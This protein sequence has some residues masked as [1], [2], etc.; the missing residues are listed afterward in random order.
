MKKVLKI[1]GIIL[2]VLLAIM[3][4]LP[5]AFKSKVGGI[6]QKQADHY[7][8]AKMTFDDLSL[9][10]FRNFPN[11]TASLNNFMIIGT[12]SFAHD[13]LVYSKSA[14][15]AIDL[16]SLMTDSGFRI[17]KV[18]LKNAKV[19]I[20]TLVSGEA[21]W[22]I[23]KPDTTP[24]EPSAD[25]TALHFELDKVELTNARVIYDDRKRDMLAD[26]QGWNGSLNGDLSS[27]LTTISTESVIES[28]NYTL[29]GMPVLKD[30]KMDFQLTFD[31]DLDRYI[32]NF[33]SNKI[34]LNAI[35]LG[36]G[37][38]ISLPG[39]NIDFDLKANTEKVTFK[40]FL[41][42][43]P[44]F[45]T[46]V[47]SAMKTAG[48]LK[49]DFF[50]KGLMTDEDW[51]A[52]GFKLLVENAMF[53]YPSL[54]KSV[55]DIQIDCNITNPGGTMDKTLVDL[56]KFHFNLGGN[57]FDLTAHVATPQSDP[58][59]KGTLAG[60]LNLGML[61]EVYPLEKGT[62]LQGRIDANLAAGGK[63][64]WLDKKQYDK[65]FLKGALAVSGI[66]Y[67]SEGMP[68]VNVQTAKMDFSPRNVH[69]T[70]LSV[71][72]GKN[73]LQANGTLNNMLGWFMHDEVLS[74]T[75]QMQS[76]YLNLND[77]MSGETTSSTDTTP[78]MAFEIPQNLDLSLNAIGKK[79]LFNSLV[80]NNA[81][82][83]LTV[84][85]GRV[86]I[87]DLSANALGGSIGV[88]GYYEALNPE[89]P[90]VAFGLDLKSVSFA[91]TF[92][93]FDFVKKIA[94]IFEQVKGNYSMK[95]DFNTLLDKHLNPDLKLLDG[96]GRMQSSG[97]SVSNIK[98][99]DVLAS[100]LKNNKLRTLAPKDLNIPFK[101]SEGKVTTSPFTVKVEGVALELGGITGL[102]KTIDYQLGVTL[103]SN[104]V[105]GGVT[106]LQGTIKGTFSKPVIK[107]NTAA[108]AKQVA[109]T[110][111]DKAL[112]STLGTNTAETIAKANEELNKK[113]DEMR[114]AAKAAGDKLISEA[115]SRGDS[116]IAKAK[117]PMVKIAAQ[118]T[119]S[120][121][122][123]EAQKKAASLLA[124][125][126]AR[127]KRMMA[128]AQTK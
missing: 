103:P 93:A 113:A 42:L 111:A 106:N 102:D 98:V 124:D 97:V 3:V 32:F 36:F 31:A 50:M 5:F 112:K 64:S 39:D 70:N 9:N 7:L 49:L 65:F 128:A 114:A 24:A 54:P 25:T 67:K 83:S 91:Q 115:Q 104:M 121:L 12:D 94:P 6:I 61:K 45:Y 2:G 79:I 118:A 47:F 74:G 127:I 81:K 110:L 99:L 126:E 96:F 71:L 90:K 8:N 80:M 109:T 85:N 38:R 73:D 18:E 56:S 84:K 13:T 34:L 95:M 48:N 82:A 17:K 125:T 51:P 20:K 35:E 4:V 72:L 66:Q 59:V 68:D 108:A 116:L 26:L 75:L 1:S 120:Q 43:V 28:V 46:K 119:A 76:N 101:I 123:I 41:S 57:T 11:I 40:Q 77:F 63:M 88:K 105:V 29:W 55:K 15:L 78:M 92:T 30:V 16:R 87:N 21:N 122:K 69:L 33:K 53:Q 44:A 89:K 62:K 60:V 27:S 117:N 14:R 19:Y 100:T 107:L 22:D 23:M 86:S 58:D 52:F 37:G 10:L